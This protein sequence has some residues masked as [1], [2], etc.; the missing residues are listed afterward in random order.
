[1]LKR[2]GRPRA[3][4]I[5]AIQDIILE[6]ILSNYWKDYQSFARTLADRILKAKPIDKSSLIEVLSQLSHPFFSFNEISKKRFVDSFPVDAVVHRIKNMPKPIAVEREIV[7]VSPEK[8]AKRKSRVTFGQIFPEIYT[9]DLDTAKEL[10][11]LL[12]VKE[13]IIQDVLRDALRE[14]RATNMVER[15]SDSSLE[16]ADLED[17]SLSIKGCSYSF[18]AVV[19]G[20]R[21]IK[22]PK[23]SFED[24]AHQIQKANDTNP[25]HILLVAAKPLKDGVVTRLVKYGK[26]CGNRDLVIL[27]DQVDLGRFLRARGII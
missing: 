18:A 15:R 22:N 12:D 23:I 25:D 6:Y 13:R 21:S 19:K 14:K 2:T 9:V 7:V 1:M 8:K 24:I 11:D 4:E 26:D 10:I 16:V 3:E 20:Y 5:I 27:V 17:F